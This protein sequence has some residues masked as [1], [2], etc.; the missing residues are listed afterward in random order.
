MNDLG[1]KI[2]RLSAIV[3]GLVFFFSGVFKLSDPVGTGLLAQEYFKFLGVS[4]IGLGLAKGIGLLLSF[5]EALTGSALVVGVY[6]KISAALAWIMTVFF[7]ILSL[8]LLIFNPSFDCGCFGEVIKLTHLQ[9]LGKN[10]LLLILCIAAFVPV[11]GKVRAMK[12]K[13]VAFYL[14]A[15]AILGLGIYS[16]AYLPLV[17]FTEYNLSAKLYD[18]LSDNLPSEGDS[19]LFTSTFIY[20]KNGQKGVF[21]ID[22][23][24]DSTWKF[25]SSQSVEKSD[26]VY[27]TDFPTLS[28]SNEKGEYM[29]SVALGRRVMVYS[30]YDVSALSEKD[31]EAVGKSAS[32]CSTIGIKPILLIAGKKEDMGAAILPE[33]TYTADY[34]TLITLNRSNGGAT[35]LTEG[36]VINKWALRK[37]PDEKTGQNLQYKSD[38]DIMFTSLSERRIIYEGFFLYTLALLLLV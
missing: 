36:A 20:E 13:F 37:L 11:P 25:V 28:F 10:L 31:W 8:A 5:A 14:V 2:K 35:Y 12:R 30:V 21:T 16:A 17:D 1:Q 32:L 3:I 26:N 34:K 7:T 6:R 38:N 18:P 4:S 33:G 9:T 29:D 23:L 15:A 24:P 22:N 19:G 27:E